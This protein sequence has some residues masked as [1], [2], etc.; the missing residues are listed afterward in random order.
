MKIN[1]YTSPVYT[2]TNSY[3]TKSRIAF[4]TTAR[5]YTNKN[6]EYIGTNSWLFRDDID[7]K[8]LTEYEKSHFK[9]KSKVNVIQFASSDGSEAYT[10]IISILENNPS[11]N[12]DKFF[13]IKAFDIDDEVVKAAKSGL[14]NT[15]SVDRM[16]LQ[17]NCEDCDYT[18][19]F[20]P[21]D[22]ELNIKNDLKFNSNKTLRASEELKKRVVFQKGDMFSL[23]KK[24]KDNSNTILLCRNILGYFENNVIEKFVKLVSDRLMSGSLFIIGDHDIKNSYIDSFLKENKF[25]M[26]M[27]NVYKKI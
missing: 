5:D 3:A 24:L 12:D 21:A 25:M 19:Y 10:K 23:I 8:Q 26:I 16:E 6:G 2:T 9:D 17:M 15:N 18:K 14:I 1:L 11:K 4:G 27:R 22:K 20:T 7:W 13:P